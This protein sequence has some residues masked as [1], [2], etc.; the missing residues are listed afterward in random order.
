LLSPPPVCVCVCVCVCIHA[1]CL[2][3]SEEGVRSSGNGVTDGCYLSAGN[4]SS[5]AWTRV[6]LNCWVISWTPWMF[7]SL[8][9]VTKIELRKASRE[10]WLSGMAGF[11]GGEE[12]QWEPVQEKKQARKRA[13]HVCWISYLKRHLYFCLCLP[14]VQHSWLTAVAVVTRFKVASGEG[15]K[16]SPCWYSCILHE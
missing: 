9:W 16:N 2:R 5:S 15:G 1:W 13:E 4:Q 7:L 12:E 10:Q 6:L 11:Q 3:K 14:L 8:K